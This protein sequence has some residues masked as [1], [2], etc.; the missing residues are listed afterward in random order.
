MLNKIRG[1]V[2][3]SVKFGESSLIVTLYT[4]KSGRQS[5]MLNA[6]RKIKATH[7]AGLFQPLFLLELE[8]Y[9]KK[10]REIQHVKEIKNAFPYQTI[11]FDVQKS[12]Q[13]IF[14]AEIL[15][16]TLR[17]E[18]NNPELFTFLET[19]LKSFDSSEEGKGLFHI[20]F[21]S[22]LTEFL[23]IYPE[24]NPAE[25]T[26]WF[27]MKRGE[28][29]SSEPLHPYFMIPEI[30]SLFGRMLQTSY[31]DLKSIKITKEQKEL[32]LLQLVDFYHIHF[33]NIGVVKSLAVLKEVFR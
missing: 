20:Y 7:K 18:E 4:D 5:Y 16:R 31:N 1:I 12:A 19:L 8:V 30:T 33:E 29:V 24:I 14:L 9:E 21:L 3:H 15:Y 2:L 32:L 6:V 22:R 27:D 10:T 23:G 28:V 25:T 13:A 17:E 26:G 11:P